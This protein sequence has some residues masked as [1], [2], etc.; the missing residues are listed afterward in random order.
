MIRRV[1]QYVHGYGLKQPI[2]FQTFGPDNPLHIPET[3]K[4]IGTKITTM[5]QVA[6][7]GDYR[8]A[9]AGNLDIITSAALTTAERVAAHSMRNVGV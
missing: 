9:Y 1:R 5:L 3:G 8:P 6:G 7:A 4:F 2:Q